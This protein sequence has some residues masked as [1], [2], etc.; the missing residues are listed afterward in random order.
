MRNIINFNVFLNTLRQKGHL[1]YEYN[2][3]HNF[4]T[5][6]DLYIIDDKYIVPSE[7]AVNPKNGELLVKKYINYDYKWVDKRGIIIPNEQVIEAETGD[8]WAKAGSLID[9]N[10]DQLNFDLN[11]PV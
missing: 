11:H 4:Q 6:V 10:T 7:Q 9:F 5:D 8:L 3:F 2:P 1:V